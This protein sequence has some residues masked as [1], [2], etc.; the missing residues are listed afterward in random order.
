MEKL[1]RITEIDLDK[2]NLIY[3]A[4]GN[5]NLVM[6]LPTHK[7]VLRIRKTKKLENDNQQEKQNTSAEYPSEKQS[8]DKGQL[9]I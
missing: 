4:E 2:E 9:L 7:A 5:A 1:N 3:R 6:S 8:Y